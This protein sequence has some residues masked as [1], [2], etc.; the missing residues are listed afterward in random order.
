[1]SRPVG[2]A[3]TTFAVLVAGA[4]L[5]RAF[6]G[7]TALFRLVLGLF[8]FGFLVASLLSVAEL[9]QRLHQLLRLPVTPVLDASDIGDL[10]TG[11]RWLRVETTVHAL[12]EPIRG[13]LE[14]PPVV[15][16]TTEVRKHEKLRGIPRFST[17]TGLVLTETETVP[18][19]LGRRGPMFRTDGDA[20]SLDVVGGVTR[21]LIA[22]AD[23]PERT[24]SALAARDAEADAHVSSG[25]V[26]EQFLRVQEAGVPEG[27]M[28]SLFGPV[29][30]ENGIDGVVVRPAGR[31][32]TGPLMTTAGWGSIAGH[33]GRRLAVLLVLAPLAALGSFLLLSMAG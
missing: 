25:Y 1:M 6:W 20:S 15:A 3:L 24:E 16:H 27:S 22:D 4:F 33:V 17:P 18:V 32:E 23:I 21:D 12:D 28:V 11:T 2:L 31:F 7:S 5:E 19:R 8:G 14:G 29:S 13:V 26:F 30:V 10:P 9:G